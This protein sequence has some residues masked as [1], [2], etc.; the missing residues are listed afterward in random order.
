M[1]L[2]WLMMLLPLLLFVVSI[3]SAVQKG[4]LEQSISAYYGGPVRDVFVGVLIA[5]AA[6]LVAYRGASLHEDYVLNASGFYAVF[7]ALIPSSLDGIL[8][9][10]AKN[11]TPDGMSRAD[12]VWALRFALTAVLLLCALLAWREFSDSERLKKLLRSSRRAMAF[13]IVS[14]AFLLAF[15]VL[16]MAQ[17]WGLPVDE[18]RMNGVTV[19]SFTLRIH[20]LAAI[21]LITGL[22]IAVFFHAFP[23]LVEQLESRPVTEADIEFQGKYRL[24]LTLMVL[25]PA[26]ALVAAFVGRTDHLVILLEWWELA[27]FCVFWIIQTLR[28]HKMMEEREAATVAEA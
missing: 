7:V 1:Y 16:A 17:L 13:V 6:C 3:A 22:A 27:L 26:A 12:Y 18:V 5:T 28:I 8:T 11:N 25:G 14:G 2:R 4:E 20:D 10:L 15:L 19:G 9:E 23:K 21:L 24:I